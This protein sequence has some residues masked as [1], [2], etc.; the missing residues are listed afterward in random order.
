MRMRYS[1]VVIMLL[2]LSS[3]DG[4]ITKN[5]KQIE[6]IL[7]SHATTKSLKIIHYDITNYLDLGDTLHVYVNGKSVNNMPFTDTVVIAKHLLG[8]N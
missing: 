6:E 4:V 7:K 8:N 3:C 1:I 2:I 5:K